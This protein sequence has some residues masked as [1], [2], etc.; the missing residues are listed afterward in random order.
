[1]KKSQLGGQQ[2]T[3]SKNIPKETGICI[4]AKPLSVNELWRGRKWKTKKY[5]A[6][7]KEIASLLPARKTIQ[8]KFRICIKFLI[9]NANRIDLDNMIKPLVDIMQKK[10][11]FIDD[12]NLT[13]L[14]AEK[15]KSN[16]NL[17]YILLKEL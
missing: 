4:Q 8:G 16:N 3:T 2:K 14:T 1:M 17:I 9:Q 13:H 11:Y 7:E 12:R 6:Y 15:E 10:G 5:E